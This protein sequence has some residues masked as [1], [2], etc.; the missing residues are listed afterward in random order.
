MSGLQFNFQKLGSVSS[1]GVGGW[2]Y[3]TQDL[4]VSQS[5]DECAEDACRRGR[6]VYVS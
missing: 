2:T 3:G 4:H 1:L 5:K 6:Y